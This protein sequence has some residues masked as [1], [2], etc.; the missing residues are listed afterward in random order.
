[1]HGSPPVGAGR[2]A[3]GDLLQGKPSIQGGAGNLKR[4]SGGDVLCGGSLDDGEP[5][6]GIAHCRRP[7]A[8]TLTPRHAAL[9]ADNGGRAAV[10][11]F[12]CRRCTR[13]RVAER[14][15]SGRS[16][17]AALVSGT[18]VAWHKARDGR[19][20]HVE[21]SWFCTLSRAILPP[22][23]ARGWPPAAGFSRSRMPGSSA[24]LFE[25]QASK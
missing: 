10:V 3:A 25:L 18:D 5:R 24:F 20:D 4:P 11:V 16:C 15:R 2:N 14:G 19:S 6:I 17:N 21:A 12:L 9:G 7:T 1:M 13:S 8:R 23:A 22:F